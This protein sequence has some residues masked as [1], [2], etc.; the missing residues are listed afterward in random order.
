MSDIV[1]RLQELESEEA[2]DRCAFVQEGG[3]SLPEP[4]GL[5]ALARDARTEIQRL[6]AELEARHMEIVELRE[7]LEGLYLKLDEAKD[8]AAYWEDLANREET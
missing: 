6:R 1:D 7:A 3:G 8:D 2:M 4:G 5:E